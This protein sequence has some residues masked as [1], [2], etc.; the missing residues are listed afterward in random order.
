[1]K[2]K[3]C[4]PLKNK[5]LRAY[6]FAAQLNHVLVMKKMFFLLLPVFMVA[7]GGGVEQYRAGIE[8]LATDWDATTSAVTEFSSTIGNDLSSFSQL[9][10]SMQLSEDV[11]KALKP[12][13]ATQWQGAQA[14]FTQALQAFAPLRTK[15][16]EFTKTW[17][18]KAAEVQALKDGLAAGKL[19]GDVAGQIASL[20][21]LV[22]QAKDSLTGWQTEHAAAKTGAQTAADALK[23]LYDT[24]NAAA[25]AKK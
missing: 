8:T 12:E 25:P 15:V 24:L 4:I 11:T 1:M 9:A 13:Q 20:T 3:T 2:I 18:E 23:A 16:G 6:T 21:T 7:C 14:A 19:E 5:C 22:T 17:G 10:G